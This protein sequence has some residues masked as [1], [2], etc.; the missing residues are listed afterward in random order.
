M[1][2]VINVQNR[3]NNKIDRVFL[4]ELILSQEGGP[5]SCELNVNLNVLCRS[6]FGVSSFYCRLGECRC[7]GG[8]VVPYENGT[9]CCKCFSW[10]MSNKKVFFLHS[11]DEKIHWSKRY[12]NHIKKNARQIR[13]YLILP[14]DVAK[15]IKPLG[16]FDVVVS[17]SN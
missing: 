13:I 9:R 17:Q 14:V 11:M 10:L 6:I 8:Q 5:G 12:Y 4:S 3:Q 1:W 16:I 7:P 2:S 15:V